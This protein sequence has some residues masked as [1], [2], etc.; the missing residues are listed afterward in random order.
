MA[1]YVAEQ[2]S[3]SLAEIN[4]SVGNYGKR[5]ENIWIDVKEFDAVG[6][7]STDDSANLQD[8]ITAIGSYETILF[9]SA[10]TDQVTKGVKSTGGTYKVSA[11][12][13]FPSNITLMFSNGAN[14]SID[15]GKTVTINGLINT[16]N[17][18]DETFTGDGSYVYNNENRLDALENTPTGSVTASNNLTATAIVVGDDGA[19]GIK[20]TAVTID[21]NDDMFM[22]DLKGISFG[23]G[24]LNGGY[25]SGAVGGQMAYYDNGGGHTFI[26]N[27]NPSGLVDGR[28]IATDGTKL[29][30][31]ETG[32][33]ENTVD[34][35]NGETGLVLLTTGDIA[36][37]TDKNY[38]DDVELE[39][40]QKLS[41]NGDEYTINITTGLG[42]TIQVGEETLA[43]FYN[44][45][46]AQ[47]N[48]GQI[49]H[50]NG[51]T[52]QSGVSMPT[53]ELAK[54]DKWT[55]CQGTLFIATHDVAIGALGLAT[56]FGKVR[57]VDTSGASQG[58]QIWLSD[59][60]AGAWSTT[61]P[62]FPSFSISLGG[63]M[64]S[65]ASG[66][67]FF[68]QTTQIRDLFNDAFD[69]VAV[70][71][72][73]FT[74]S[75]DG[76]TITGSLVNKA[77][78]ARD[79]V[80]CFSDGFH[81]FDTTP[82]ATVSLTAGTD[83]NPQINYIFIPQD[84]KTLTANTTGFPET[85]HVSI[86]TVF[87]QSASAVQTYDALKNHNWNDYIRAVGD[88]G[89]IQNMARAIRE[90]IP[91]QW[92]TGAQG[93]ATI[94]TN[95][96]SADNV[97]VATT[98][99]TVM[100][101]HY[102]SVDA[103]DTSAGDHI[104][105]VNDSIAPYKLVTDLNGELTDASGVSMSEQ[106]FSIVVWG[107]A[108]SAGE[109]P[110]LMANL[111]TDSYTVGLGLGKVSLSSAINDIN[112]YAV[113]DIPSEFNGVGFLIA[114]FT[115]T[116][117]IADSGTWV[118]EDT[119]DLRGKVPNLSAGGSAG[120]SGVTEFLSLTDTPSSY[121]GE[122][123]KV[124][125][126]NTGE[127]G[128]EFITTL[129]DPMTTRGDIIYRNASNVTARL[130]I[131]ASGTYLYSNGTDVSWNTP[132][133]TGDV[134]ASANLADREL[135][136]GDGGAKG[137]KTGSGITWNS[138][139]LYFG[140]TN[141]LSFGASNDLLIKHDTVNSINYIRTLASRPIEIQNGSTEKIA[142][143]N[144][145]GSV[146]LYYDNSIKFATTTDGINVTG[147]VTASGNVDIQSDVA[148]LRLGAGN[149][150]SLYH[151][152]TI[153]AIKSTNGDIQIN[154][155]TD[156]M[157][158]FK[159]DGSV[160]LYYDNAKKFETTTGGA[161]I[162][163]DLE[164]TDVITAD[165][166]PYGASNINSQIGT[167]YTTV[168]TD[169]DKKIICTNA[170]AITVT[171]PPNSSVAYPIGTEFIVVKGGAG[172]VT[173]AGGSGVT[174]NS[175]ESL[176]TIETQYKGMSLTKTAT[177]TWLVLGAES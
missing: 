128:L 40:V 51:A 123:G 140:D 12:L 112:N 62:S 114:R 154:Y 34:A 158:I 170:S 141:T 127:T 73:T 10:K 27:I 173:V 76:T 168:L 103:I 163:G 121:S 52:T 92:I 32:A 145:D 25:I 9:F 108:N 118:L 37:D 124:V 110:Q 157:A 18:L 90:K 30:G 177:D 4:A 166:F 42:A 43:L 58:E 31:I 19:K 49:L 116:H 20:T 88:G 176:D 81:I 164:V 72:F 106:T 69:G 66:T 54:S 143:F 29:D 151:N 113:Y 14:L 60:V 134:T 24:A 109:S 131:G 98:A 102:Q 94:T 44:G 174:L 2:I 89:Y 22:A 82:P 28:D 16:M 56:F 71:K 68:N 122:G 47:I 21:D 117:S 129:T 100:Q 85:E 111:P 153:N 97:D 152:G 5:I 13:T 142:I 17:K 169:S 6:D 26:G 95:A 130:G 115:F 35:V 67:I 96:G 159:A 59:S 171:I 104:H 146:D 46:G 3:E 175:A 86:G 149:D 80:L 162:T 139:V 133:G 23:S 7:G 135:V 172:N 11:D 107:V 167:T 79:V 155:S 83:T 74:L 70:E 77:D 120:G 50:P 132:A 57:G 75:S 55:T 119:E 61:K 39:A 138:S 41:W 99:G 150:F 160:E 33:Q 45:T 126:V 93:T 147:S 156:N 101:M 53:V 1:E 148:S 105:I 65:L 64:D 48:N 15:S 91:A 125:A 78:S 36:E 84:T 136:L 87:V 144:P 165:R 38:V 161:K 137:V 63:T 8:A